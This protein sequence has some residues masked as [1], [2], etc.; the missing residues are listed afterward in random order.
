MAGLLRRG[1]AEEGHTVEVVHDGAPAL[2][3]A[4]RSRFDVVV[5]D[6]MLPGLSGLEVC[7]RLRGHQVWVPIL[8]LTARDGVNDRVRGLDS[9]ADDYLIKPFHVEELLARLRALARRGPV[10]R[11]TVLAAGELQLDPASHRCWRGGEEIGLTG[12]EY[13]LLETFLRHPGTVLTRDLLW[14]QC[15][16]FAEEPRS[17]VVD[18]H[19]R[20]LREKIDRRF[21]TAALET[22]RGAGYRVRPDGG[23]PER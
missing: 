2:D 7:R 16:D 10:P 8:L 11:P 18:V 6:V 12:K 9:G 5:L 19:V 23:R 1:L 20:A 14:E 22:V 4:Q 3:W 17:N 13:L 15:W 21:G